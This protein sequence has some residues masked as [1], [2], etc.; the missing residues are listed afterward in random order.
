[1]TEMIF[2]GCP[3]TSQE[4]IMKNI[5]SVKNIRKTAKNDLLFII[6]VT[7]ILTLK[8]TYFAS[9]NDQPPF[10]AVLCYY[11]YVFCFF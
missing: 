6:V 5:M 3:R 11:F 4:Y 8:S 1:M 10:L 9:S 2:L 7:L